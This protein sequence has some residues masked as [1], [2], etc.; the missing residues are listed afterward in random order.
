MTGIFMKQSIF[1]CLTNKMLESHVE[2]M[3]IFVILT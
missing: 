3:N 2:G 1:V